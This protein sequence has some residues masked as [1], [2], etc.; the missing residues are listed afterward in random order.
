MSNAD[1][2]LTYIKDE[3]LEDDD[4]DVTIDTSLFRDKLLNSL[5]LVSLISFI[6]K[7]F[8][9]K[10]SPSEVSIDNLD[11]ASSMAGFIERKLSE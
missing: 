9:I 1:A 4:V 6:E 2:I 11:T 10:I 5:S 8:N 7:T 3:L